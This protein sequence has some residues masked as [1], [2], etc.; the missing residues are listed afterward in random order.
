[1]LVALTSL[2]HKFNFIV[3]YIQNFKPNLFSIVKFF[4]CIFVQFLLIC[5]LNMLLRLSILFEIFFLSVDKIW[6]FQIPFAKNC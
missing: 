2:I 4:Y 3:N 6:I 5:M 1:M